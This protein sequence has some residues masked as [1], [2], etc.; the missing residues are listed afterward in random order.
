MDLGGS[1]HQ[2]LSEMA[3]HKLRTLLTLLGMVFGVGAVIAMLS[4]GEGAQREAL[5]LID[6]MGLRNLLVQAKTFD[7]ETLKEIR[8]DSLGLTTRDMQAA[9]E[10]LPFVEAHSAEKR[11]KTY[12]LFSQH[13]AS[14]SVVFAV[15]PS[16]FDMASLSAAE[17]RLLTE[18]DD[19]QFTQ[20]AVLG[21]SVADDLFP[22]GNALGGQVK[23]NHLWLE[24]VGVLAEKHLGKEEFQGVKLGDE[25]SRVYLPL[26]T[27]FKRLKFDSLEDEIDAFRLRLEASADPQTAAL[28]LSHLLSRR[29]SDVDDFELVVPAAL[30]AQQQQTQQIFTIVMSCIAGISLLVGGIGIMNIMLAT[31]LERTKEIGLLRA[32]GA[33]KVDIRR[34][35]LVESFVISAVG[36][37]IGVG[38]G[39]VLAMAIQSFADWSVAWAP[40]A[41]LLAVGICLVTGVVFGW[42]PAAKAAEL[43]PIRALHTE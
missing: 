1:L 38:F 41:V 26:Q 42:Y 27:A 10:T 37:L 43:D 34:Q 11:V 40:S 35:F 14:D 36:A 5:Q 24:V 13:G 28:A 32:V 12:D 33:R 9:L 7:R 8:E 31:V 25:S 18:V 4:I 6:S 20:V 22:D 21:Q 16:H 29:H 39:I 15:T 23:V 30:L 3:H 2:A 17:G 19:A